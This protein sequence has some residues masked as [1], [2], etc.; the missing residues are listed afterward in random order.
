MSDSENT[1]NN[2]LNLSIRVTTDGFSL[3]SYDPSHTLG[4]SKTA[5]ANIWEIS[6]LELL[7]LLSDEEMFQLSYNSVRLIVE[8][9]FYAL[10]PEA[11][12][13]DA[14]AS[15]FIF[16]IRDSIPKNFKTI[17]NKLLAWNAVLVYAVPEAVHA[18]FGKILPDIETEHHV[19]AY[20]ND[21]VPLDGGTSVHINLRKNC[22]DAVVLKN[23]AL[24]MINTYNTE[25]NE[26]IAYYVLKIYDQLQLSAEECPIQVQSEKSKTAIISVLKK[27]IKTVTSKKIS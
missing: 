11:F 4:S 22:F 20:I 8:T 18:A 19:L 12:Y 21:S 15:Q 14:L 16:G 13:S 10:I 5:S 7:N 24:Q 2:I 9:D 25:S 3:S 23:G 1:N 26:D 17:S 6:E 27:Y